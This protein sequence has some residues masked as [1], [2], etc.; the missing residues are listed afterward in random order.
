M[1]WHFCYL[2]RSS[3]VVLFLAECVCLKPLLF[4]RFDKI[5]IQLSWTHAYVIDLVEVCVS[6]CV[7][8]HDNLKTIVDICFL[9]GSCVDWRKISEEIACRDNGL[10]SRS[11]LEGSRWLGK[12]MSNSVAGSEVLSY[13]MSVIVHHMLVFRITSKHTISVLSSPPSDT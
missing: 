8:L 11:F 2:R 7:C 6:A 4:F 1:C 3:E 13:R 10:R 9:L 5:V 12:V